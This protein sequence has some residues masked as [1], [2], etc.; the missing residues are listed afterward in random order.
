M[1]DIVCTKCGKTKCQCSSSV[2]DDSLVRDKWVGTTSYPPLPMNLGQSVELFETPRGVTAD[3]L[4]TTQSNGKMNPE[5]S[6]K[7]TRQR[8]SVDVKRSVISQAHALEASAGSV[9]GEMLRHNGLYGRSSPIV[10]V[11]EH[12]PAGFGGPEAG[13]Q[14]VARRRHRK[15][16]SRRR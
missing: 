1:G 11:A 7:P 5:V 3:D 6:A 13:S 12:G 2:C 9:V 8:H 10:A 4:G 14:G 15:S 16:R